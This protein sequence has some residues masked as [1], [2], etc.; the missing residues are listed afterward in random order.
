MNRTIK[1]RAWDGEE[2]VTDWLILED[3]GGGIFPTSRTRKALV[4]MQFTGLKDSKGVDIYE[5]DILKTRTGEI[6]TCD[7]I[8]DVI[9]GINYDDEVIGNIYQNPELLTPNT[10]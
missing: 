4:V 5:G 2:I 8:R 10:P 9:R 6:I 3:R 7:D 1:F